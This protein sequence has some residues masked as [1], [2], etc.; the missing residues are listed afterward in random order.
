MHNTFVACFFIKVLRW[1][2]TIRFVYIIINHGS[3]GRYYRVQGNLSDWAIFDNIVTDLSVHLL[4]IFNI[5]VT[6]CC[7]HYFKLM[8]C[9]GR[10]CDGYISHIRLQHLTVIPLSILYLY[11]YY[12][13]ASFP[14][15]KRSDLRTFCDYDNIIFCGWFEISRCISTGHVLWRI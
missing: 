10:A 7:V 11:T 1:P 13:Y 3:S 5:T 12:V 9:N 6:T 2:V 8:F 15:E 14:H 4:P